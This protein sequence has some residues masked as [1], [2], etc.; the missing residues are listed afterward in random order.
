MVR[1]ITEAPEVLFQQGIIT[2]SPSISQTNDDLTTV[3]ILKPS[4]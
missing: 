4:N 1:H 2:S 3:G